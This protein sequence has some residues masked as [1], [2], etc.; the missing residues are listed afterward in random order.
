MNQRLQE[1][2]VSTQTQKLITAMKACREARIALD[3][4]SQSLDELH[5]MQW[6]GYPLGAKAIYRG[7]PTSSLD[8]E[9]IP[10]A[11]VLLSGE[12]V[13]VWT[14][15]LS[16]LDRPLFEQGKRDWYHD[17][18]EQ[19]YRISEESFTRITQEIFEKEIPLQLH[20]LVVRPLSQ[21]A[22]PKRPAYTFLTDLQSLELLDPPPEV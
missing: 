16:N 8:R 1:D 3:Y 9:R 14:L 10:D 21:G 12:A 2:I 18:L 5:Y 19:N 6:Q 15:Y 13:Y 7:E 11:P 22:R 4:A 20:C 17:L